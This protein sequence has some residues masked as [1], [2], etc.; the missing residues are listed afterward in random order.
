MQQTMSRIDEKIDWF[1][2]RKQKF[3]KWKLRSRE[4]AVLWRERKK[5]T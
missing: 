4:E 5:A 1:K 2:G 3:E